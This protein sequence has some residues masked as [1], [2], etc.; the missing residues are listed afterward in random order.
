MYILT[1]KCSFMDPPFEILQGKSP[2]FCPHL[3][4]SLSKLMHL[5]LMH[6]SGPHI[7]SY[8]GG[9]EFKNTLVIDRQ[10]TIHFWIL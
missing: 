5:L 7:V 10:T 1:S 2:L 4:V 6:D 8:T 9:F 3:I